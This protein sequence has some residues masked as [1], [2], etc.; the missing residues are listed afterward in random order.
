MEETLLTSQDLADL[1]CVDVRRVQQLAKEGILPRVTRGKYDLATCVKAYIQYL[2][3][4]SNVDHISIAQERAKQSRMDTEL[5]QIERDKA[6][7]LVVLA[8]DVEREWSGIFKALLSSVQQVIKT[9]A[10]EAQMSRKERAK[11]ERRINAVLDR[12]AGNI[13]RRGA[14]NK[15][16]ARAKAK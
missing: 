8:A 12:L 15:A 1:L 6:I 14:R 3:G 10:L 11:L 16:K 5:K 2:K 13:Q 7:G 4:S 9:A